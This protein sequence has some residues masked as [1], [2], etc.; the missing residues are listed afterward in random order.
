MEMVIIIATCA[1]VSAGIPMNGVL[2]ALNHVTTPLPSTL[3]TQPYVETP[4]S[5]ED[6][7]VMCTIVGDHCAGPA[8]DVLAPCKHVPTFGILLH[9]EGY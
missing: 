2:V 7:L 9:W 3:L 4:P 5:G 8:G 1:M 6:C